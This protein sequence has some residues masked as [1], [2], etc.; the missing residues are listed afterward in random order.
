MIQQLANQTGREQRSDFTAG[1]AQVILLI[2]QTQR[3]TQTDF[4]SAKRMIQNS[5][6]QFP[7]LYYIFLTNDVQTFIDLTDFNGTDIQRR[8]QQVVQN[9]QNEHY[10]IIDANSLHVNDFSSAIEDVIRNIPKR[11]VA[12]F[13][14][15]TGGKRT[16]DD[17]MARSEHEEYISPGQ[18]IRYRI[19]PYFLRMTDEIA[20]QFQGVEYGDF[21]VCLSRDK[22]FVPIECKSVEN[23]EYV[24]FNLT[25]PCS[26]ASD[27]T[28]VYFT[29]TLD[30]SNMRCTES[31]CRFPDQVRYFVRHHGLR[32]E[33]DGRGGANHL[34]DN[35]ITY[36]LITFSV[37]FMNF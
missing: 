10:Y 28:G 5:L 33:I 22:F 9:H 32:C 21:T 4:D 36:L 24:W 1:T 8:A 11:L 34:T 2:S 19:S 27:C 17:V 31:D 26:S 16:W 30:S 37:I 35:I 14:R 13:C 20:V 6:L 23:L 18:E 29:V 3:I 7:D 25:N 12:P 15:N